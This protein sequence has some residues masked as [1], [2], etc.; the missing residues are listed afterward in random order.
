[1]TIKSTFLSYNAC[2]MQQVHIAALPPE[3]SQEILHYDLK[4]IQMQTKG[5]LKYT[6]HH[7]LWLLHIKA[8]WPTDSNLQSQEERSKTS[9]RRLRL[10]HRPLQLPLSKPKI[11]KQHQSKELGFHMNMSEDHSKTDRIWFLLLALSQ[12][13]HLRSTSWKKLLNKEREHCSCEK[14]EEK[15]QQSLQS[16][17]KYSTVLSTII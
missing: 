11:Q 6:L 16:L 2:W 5:C 10:T 7:F 15:K 8:I 13:S 3:H 14:R 9:A 1:M 12:D 4:I 17:R